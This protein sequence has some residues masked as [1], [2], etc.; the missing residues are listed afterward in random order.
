MKLATIICLVLSGLF[1]W[2]CIADWTSGDMKAG[3][4]AYFLKY[5]AIVTAIIGISM[6][7]ILAFRK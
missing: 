1:W 7:V 6:L 5:P 3:L 2:A 4:V